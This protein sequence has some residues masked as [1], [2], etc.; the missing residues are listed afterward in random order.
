[1]VWRLWATWQA[2]G[3]MWTGVIETTWRMLGPGLFF[4]RSSE[5]A[6]HALL[7]PQLL[8]SPDWHTQ[9]QWLGG[10]ARTPLSLS[11]RSPVTSLNV[12]SHCGW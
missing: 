4:F 6:R 5:R 2:P 8:G 1:M 3:G 12:N 10:M 7:A 11:L 9:P